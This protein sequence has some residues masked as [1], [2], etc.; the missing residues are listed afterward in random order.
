LVLKESPD[1]HG[2]QLFIA[3]GRHERKPE[4]I[5]SPV[6]IGSMCEQEADDAVILPADC[7]GERRVTVSSKLVQIRTVLEQ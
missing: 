3:D 1:D 2:V 5:V 4:V 6:R 7:R